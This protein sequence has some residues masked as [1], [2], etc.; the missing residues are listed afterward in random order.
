MIADGL[1][2]RLEGG[3]IERRHEGE[4]PRVALGRCSL[5]PVIHEAGADLAQATLEARRVA[6]DRTAGEPC[7]PRAPVQAVARRE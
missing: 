2:P 1:D 5:H 6:V 7:P 4:L 3:P